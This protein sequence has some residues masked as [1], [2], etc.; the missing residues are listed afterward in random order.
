M[1]NV[2][3]AQ[4]HASA[5]VRSQTW[6]KLLLLQVTMS[7]AIGQM[8]LL[9]EHSAFLETFCLTLLTFENQGIQDARTGRERSE[10]AAHS[11]HEM[12]TK[13][14]SAENTR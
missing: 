14:L 4:E 7:R 5:G 12:H 2:Q 9:F 8:L 1:K 3:S 11:L 6:S 10:L 13:L